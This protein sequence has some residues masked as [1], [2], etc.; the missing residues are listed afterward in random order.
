[1][2]E[3]VR[4]SKT[5]GF[6]GAIAAVWLL[7]AGPAWAGG[8]SDAGTL[9]SLLC[10]TFASSL[11]IACP[12][13]PTYA[14]TTT[15]P[16]TPISPATPI[17][18][19]L[20]AWQNVA[21]DIVRMQDSDCVLFG[22]ANGPGNFYCSQLAVNATNGPA[23]SPGSG[24]PPSTTTS[25][26]ALSTLNSLAFVSNA[27]S[28]TVTQNGDPNANSFI[29]AAVL[30]DKSGLDIFYDY[31]AAQSPQGQFKVVISVPLAV[32]VNGAA[33]ETSVVATLTATCNGAAGCSNVTVSGNFPSAKKNPP[34]SP[35]DLGLSFQSFFAP[36]PNSH[37]PHLIIELQAPL[38][39]STQ[40]DPLYFPISGFESL[41]QCANG[42]NPISGYCNAFSATNV[43]KG[44]APKFLTKTAVGMAPSAAPQCPGNQPGLPSPPG[45]L[46]PT[47]LPTNPTQPLS[48]TFGFC[49]SFSG[50][51]AA[52]F[53]LA[54]AP[55][56]TTIT[57][58]PVNPSPNGAAYPA[59]PS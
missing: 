52:A 16:A 59:C 51:P 18:L 46:C 3:R 17:I 54:I 48:P 44:F 15:T 42:S 27:T 22:T 6:A 33:T 57:S 10:N 43:P 4:S 29:Y 12:Q 9:L 58:S 19:E 7:C 5:A 50:N 35:A 28:L 45:S 55:D 38:L 14:D 37:T 26:A 1:M 23:N 13:Y 31:V 39:M 53:F 40:T 47:N 2:R 41:P 20:A 21:P 25:P 34:Y 32:L 30:E 49:A 8:A 11:V 36:S 24:P 56:G